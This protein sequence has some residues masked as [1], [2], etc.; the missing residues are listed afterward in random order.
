ME[1]PFDNLDDDECKYEAI[2]CDKICQALSLLSGKWK[3]KILYYIGYHESI[4]Y[5]EL[6]RQV[7]PITHKMLS[8]QLK[9]LESDGL[10]IRIEYPQIPP[11]VE[12]RL[13]EKG[14]GL[15]P[16]FDALYEWIIKYTL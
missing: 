4:R 3:L 9:E 14:Y 8:S 6:K 12:Y 10:I 11:K 1:K 2:G 5:G 13:S 16:M 7:I 15:V